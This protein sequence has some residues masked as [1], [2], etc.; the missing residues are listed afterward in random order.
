M[1]AHSLIADFRHPTLGKAAYALLALA[2]AFL[3]GL[4]YDRFGIA[5][6]MAPHFAF[7]R[8]RWHPRRAPPASAD[9]GPQQCGG[10]A[11][12]RETVTRRRWRIG[13]G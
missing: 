8:L 13:G 9:A 4:L 1:L 12:A 3:L 11:G 2:M 6:S 5:A 10:L 7:Y